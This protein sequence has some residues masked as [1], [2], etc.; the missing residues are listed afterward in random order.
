[1]DQLSSFCTRHITSFSIF[2]KW[3][4]VEVN[5]FEISLGREEGL[6]AASRRQSNFGQSD[7]MGP[8]YKTH[9]ISENTPMINRKVHKI[10]YRHSWR[11]A[12]KHQFY[13]QKQDTFKNVRVWYVI[14]NAIGA[15]ASLQADRADQT[16]L[17]NHNLSK[18]WTC[19]LAARQIMQRELQSIQKTTIFNG[20]NATKFPPWISVL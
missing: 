8:V 17:L 12:K 2:G 9:A 14:G 3:S 7:G 15:R 5:H 1:M 10:Y 11:K 16:N 20:K 13:H 18:K 19:H 4:V 6:R